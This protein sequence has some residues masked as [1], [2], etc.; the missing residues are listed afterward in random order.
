MAFMGLSSLGNIVF[1]ELFFHFL[2]ILMP[3]CQ[4]VRTMV[5]SLNWLSVAGNWIAVAWPT[6]GRCDGLVPGWKDPI[7]VAFANSELVYHILSGK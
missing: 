5:G 2:R 7:K 3:S 4:R 6:I 1:V